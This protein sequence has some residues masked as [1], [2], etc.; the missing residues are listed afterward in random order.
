MNKIEARKE[1]LRE[2]YDDILGEILEINEAIEYHREEISDLKRNRDILS[3]KLE[4]IDN[5]LLR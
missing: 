2:K 5:E 1:F 4:K 3:K